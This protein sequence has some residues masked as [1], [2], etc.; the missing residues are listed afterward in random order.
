MATLTSESPE[1]VLSVMLLD[2]QNVGLGRGGLE[3]EQSLGSSKNVKK[4][5]HFLVFEVEI[6]NFYLTTKNLLDAWI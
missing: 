4:K 5:S 6:A 1:L 2:F 3:N